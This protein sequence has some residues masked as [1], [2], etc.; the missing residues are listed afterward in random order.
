MHLAFNIKFSSKFQELLTELWDL[1][2]TAPVV[3]EKYLSASLWCHF[4]HFFL[5]S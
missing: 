3:K 4:D 2:L 1:T 5:R